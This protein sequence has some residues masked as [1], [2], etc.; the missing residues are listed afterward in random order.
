[1]RKKEEDDMTEHNLNQPVPANDQEVVIEVVSVKGLDDK[2]VEPY[3][4]AAGGWLG[5]VRRGSPARCFVCDDYEFECENWQWRTGP[6]AFLFITLHDRVVV[7]GLCAACFNHPDAAARLD[8]A[9]EEKM[10]KKIPRYEVIDRDK[11]H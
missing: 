9:M 5:Q 7:G 11:V 10:F 6:A 3:H 4:L 2:P 8:A 1:L